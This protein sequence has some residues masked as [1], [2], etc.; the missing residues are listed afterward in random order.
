[1][2]TPRWWA[3][4]FSEANDASKGMFTAGVRVVLVAGTIEVNDPI[5]CDFIEYV[6][7]MLFAEY[8]HYLNFL[9]RN[10]RVDELTALGTWLSISCLLLSKERRQS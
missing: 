7:N 4:C 6:K 3:R 8:S 9:E 2:C 1:M 10:G 5:W